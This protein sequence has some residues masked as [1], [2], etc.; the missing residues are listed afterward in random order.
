MGLNLKSSEHDIEADVV[1]LKG[2]TS[3]MVDM[4]TFQFKDL[5]AGKITPEELFMDAY[6]EEIYGLENFRS[7]TKR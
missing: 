2:L 6:V 4:G 3:P 5:N 7:Y 1:P